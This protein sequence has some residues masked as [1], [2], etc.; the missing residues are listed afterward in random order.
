MVAINPLR[1]AKLSAVHARNIRNYDIDGDD[2]E[3]LCMLSHVLTTRI[4]TESS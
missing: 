1:S 4:E 3:A 2:L